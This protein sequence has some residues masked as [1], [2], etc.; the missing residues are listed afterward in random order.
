MLAGTIQGFARLVVRR[1]LV[2]NA[3]KKYV[4][5]LQHK[6][7]G[8]CAA[9]MRPNLCKRE[10]AGQK[11]KPEDHCD[12]FGL[13]VWNKKK[14]SDAKKEV[15]VMKIT[16]QVD[17]TEKVLRALSTA[18]NKTN[19]TEDRDDHSYLVALHRAI[20]RDISMRKFHIEGRRFRD[21]YGNV[22][23]TIAIYDQRGSGSI[24]CTESK[25]YG[26]GDHWKQTAYDIL[27][28]M[29]FVTEA[30]RSNHN[31]NRERFTYSVTDGRRKDLHNPKHHKH[32]TKRIINKTGVNWMGLPSPGGEG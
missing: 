28:S 20:D 16:I 6:R 15:I 24:L 14:I 26:Y 3:M 13:N 4:S 17:D 32:L 30:D 25:T 29:E 23:H 12:N 11:M 5:T 19:N 21:S 22:Y 8:N 31:L 2:N 27:V 18:C 1:F 9:W 7:C 10:A